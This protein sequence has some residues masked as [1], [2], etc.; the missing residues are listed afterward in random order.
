MKV[1]KGTIESCSLLNTHCS[2]FRIKRLKIRKNKYTQLNE[3]IT[4]MSMKIL[5]KHFGLHDVYKCENSML[6][7][8]MLILTFICKLKLTNEFRF[9][10]ECC[11][12]H[13]D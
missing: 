12:E 9:R 1:I 11:H 10:S 13:S 6:L 5:K 8:I 3:I 4:I 2:D 7:V